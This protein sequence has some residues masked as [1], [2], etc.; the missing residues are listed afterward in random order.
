MHASK[1]SLTNISDFEKNIYQLRNSKFN[2]SEFFCV[3][4]TL[5]F[6]Y[7]HINQGDGEQRSYAPLHGSI[8]FFQE[9]LT[10][11]VY[12]RRINTYYIKWCF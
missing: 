7:C 12:S 4:Y 9:R 8:I 11:A 6:F 1:E 3:L 2:F 10:V 5:R